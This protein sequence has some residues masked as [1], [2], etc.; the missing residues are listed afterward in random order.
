MLQVQRNRTQMQRVFVME[1]D[2]RGK[3][4]SR[5]ESNACSNVT[6][7]TVRREASDEDQREFDLETR[8][9]T[10]E[11][12][13]IPKIFYSCALISRHWRDDQI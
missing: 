13:I 8:V 3:E 6:K 2:E 1:E 7:D 4:K 12:I 9:I 5:G 10:N 11:N